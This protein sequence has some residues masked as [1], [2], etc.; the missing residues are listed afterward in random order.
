MSDKIEELKDEEVIKYLL[1]QQ[2]YYGEDVIYGR[3]RDVSEYI[4]GS[5]YVIEAFLKILVKDIQLIR[6]KKYKEYL[7]IF[8][9]NGYGFNYEAVYDRFLNTCKNLNQELTPQL[10]TSFLV[11]EMLMEIRKDCF[12]ETLN[13]IRIIL[14]EYVTR[15]NKKRKNQMDLD[16][17]SIINQKMEKMR[18]LYSINSKDI[19]M[20][21]N[22]SFLKMI[23]F[24]IEDFKVYKHTTKLLQKYIENVVALLNSNEF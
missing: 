17:E 5:G 15:S 9:N 22:L 19:G 20:I 18:H 10:V 8:S 12:D 7:E 24:K 21:Y 23:A 16:L 3:T 6:D 13:E 4:S 11:S 2:F 14:I 1:F